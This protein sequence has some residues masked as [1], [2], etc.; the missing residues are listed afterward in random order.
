MGKATINDV[1]RLAGVS[2]KTVSRVVNREPNVRPSTS[3]RV[4]RVIAALDYRPNQ[5]ARSLASHRSRLIG[6]VYDDPSA[7]EVP[8][9]GYVA[10][11]QSGALRACKAASY[12]LLIHPCRYASK[13]VV[14][15]L[16]ALVEH[17]RPAGI[18]L[19]APLSN[20]PRIIRAIEAG[21]TPLVRL[22]PG[23]GSIKQLAIATNDREICAEM[24]RYLVSL[25][26]ERIAFIKG[27]P[28]HKAVG[29]RYL[30]Y[31]DGLRDSGIKLSGELVAQGDNSTGSGE[32]C[33]GWLLK[34]KRRPTAIFAAND[35]MAAGVMRVAAKLG[36][37]VPGELSVAGCD[38]ISLARQI[39]PAL[40]TIRQPLVDMAERAARALIESS[41]QDSSGRDIEVVPGTIQVR[42]ST[43]P[44]PA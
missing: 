35:D 14:N 37:A 21:G 9:T 30:G 17:V 18:I 20:M 3:A 23:P 32:E 4:E 26:H 40:T 16:R 8:S 31:C 12:E 7:Y 29:N 10:R 38:D 19:A 22:S 43:G 44:A 33:A 41:R 6:L 36:I 34:R 24:T 15:E 13:D 39:Y 1:A 5:F 11:L 28:Q 42:E 25:G 2:P 27:H